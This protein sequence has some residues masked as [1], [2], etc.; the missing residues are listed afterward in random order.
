MSTDER[1]SDL[2]TTKNHAPAE[3]NDLDWQLLSEF[4]SKRFTYSAV[5]FFGNFPVFSFSLS[6]KKQFKHYTEARYISAPEINKVSDSYSVDPYTGISLC[7]SLIPKADITL[8]RKILALNKDHHHYP[9]NFYRIKYDLRLSS[10]PQGKSTVLFGLT[11]PEL[12]S[13]NFVESG[14]PVFSVLFPTKETHADFLTAYQSFNTASQEGIL[15]DALSRPKFNK[16]VNFLSTNKMFELK[17][18]FSIPNLIPLLLLPPNIVIDLARNNDQIEVTVQGYNQIAVLATFMLSKIRN[19][20]PELTSFCKRIIT[21]AR[22]DEEFLKSDNFAR[23]Q[24][25]QKFPALIANALLGI[26]SEYM[27]DW[28]TPDQFETFSQFKAKRLASSIRISFAPDALHLDKA[29]YHPSVRRSDVIALKLLF[30]DVIFNDHFKSTRA[31]TNKPTERVAFFVYIPD[32]KESSTYKHDFKKTELQFNVFLGCLQHSLRKTPDPDHLEN[33][34]MLIATFGN[35][36]ADFKTTLASDYEKKLLGHTKETLTEKSIARNTPII[37][38]LA[39]K[40][41]LLD[42]LLFDYVKDKLT[43]HFRTTYIPSPN[44]R[45]LVKDTTQF[46]VWPLKSLLRYVLIDDES[47]ADVLLHPRYNLCHDALHNTEKLRGRVGQLNDALPFSK[48]ELRN[49]MSSS[50]PS[51]LVIPKLQHSSRNEFKQSLVF[52]MINPTDHDLRRLRLTFPGS[53]R[54]VETPRKS[55]SVR[56]RAE[57]L[58]EIF[59]FLSEEIGVKL[60]MLTDYANIDAK[61]LTRQE[62]LKKLEDL[63]DSWIKL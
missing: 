27:E 14:C 33:Y 50:E 51:L 63:S 34:H 62:L 16:S 17:L 11:I 36:I 21:R 3:F 59:D 5:R 43:G 61:N 56:L 18:S 52:T 42:N 57:H 8:V 41:D 24:D 1:S 46:E 53:K 28:G 10:Q 47:E 60:Q 44:V 48:P 31:V 30:P 12:L 25:Q 54:I 49:L 20:S 7:S 15:A 40:L 22:K 29:L 37:L 39:D 38:S 55:F 23:L 9:R 19:L 45:L 4:I 13:Y 2:G 32:E 58:R 26:N 35:R 6:R